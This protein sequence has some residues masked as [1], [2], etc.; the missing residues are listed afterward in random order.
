MRS[1]LL[2]SALAVSAHA[3]QT[4]R[5][6]LGGGE[7]M[8]LVRIQP[9]VFTMG[10]APDAKH[11]VT[12]SKPFFIGKLPVT[13]GQFARFVAATNYRTEAE[14]GASGGFGW[15]G[16]KLVQKKEYTW[17][18]PGF[19]QTDEHPVV[20]MDFADA[21][22]FCAWLSRQ[23]GRVVGLPT[24]AQWE[25]AARG[26]GN[27]G[28]AWTAANS[29]KGTQPAGSNK[30]NGSGVQD[31]I[32][33]A[34]EWC[35]DWF[36]PYAPA[37]VTEPL[38]TN[39]SLSDKPR[40]VLRGGAFSRPVGD[41]SVTK[42]YRNDPGARNA[43][44]G[45][46]VVVADVPQPQANTPPKPPPPANPPPANPPPVIPP[47]V[48]PPPAPA[49]PSAAQDAKSDRIYLPGQ[50]HDTEDNLAETESSSG[51]HSGWLIWVLVGVGALIVWKLM[52]SL[53]GGMRARPLQMPDPGIGVSTSAGNGFNVRIVQDGFWIR[54]SVPIGTPL[55]VQWNGLTASHSRTVSYRPGN[56]GQFVF[57]GE[58]PSGVTVS[59]G[60]TF[61]DSTSQTGRMM[62][63]MDSILPD[64]GVN[65]PIIRPTPQQ[66]GGSSYTHSHPSAY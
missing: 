15:E 18:N 27:A 21:K 19:P 66:Q 38:Q 31:M 29:P 16:G 30:A 57:T 48:I 14:K 59:V 26:G 62:G 63:M 53:M 6:P 56:E 47:P 51:G 4:I 60:D 37:A 13:R 52:R 3:Q 9:G 23:S 11:E 5:L 1:L 33:N 28:E 43:D 20:M 54:G 40:R 44:N 7:E 24:E 39:Q 25:L 41:A 50:S 42:R 2:L 22:A 8:E 45:F 12:L 32:G 64:R 58:R 49:P 10:E 55:N 65:R 61:D 36:A 17:R 46:R 34:W 35:E